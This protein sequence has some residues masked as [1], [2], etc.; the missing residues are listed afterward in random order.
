MTDARARA[1]GDSKPN[2]TRGARANANPA[3]A[4]GAP[5]NFKLHQSTNLSIFSIP[6]LYMDHSWYFQDDELSF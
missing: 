6:H 3:R 4:S 1:R 5:F 2:R